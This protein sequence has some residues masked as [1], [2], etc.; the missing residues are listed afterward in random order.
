MLPRK[1]LRTR[2][3]RLV[4]LFTLVGS[5][6]TSLR[7]TVLTN[8]I[9][10]NSILGFT[11]LK[12]VTQP[13]EN[14]LFA[15]SITTN[16]PGQYTFSYAGV[17]ELYSVHAASF[18]LEFTP[19]FVRGSTPLLNNMDNPGSF[20]LSL[21][22]GQSVLL[23]Y[24]DDLYGPFPNPS[25]FGV[26]DD[27]DGYGWFKLTRTLRGLTVSDSATAIGG[28]IVVGTYTQIPE[29]ASLGLVLPALFGLTMR[30]GRLQF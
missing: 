7:A 10:F 9:G 26:P 21:G 6:F 23:A 29:P 22:V 13:G 20:Q 11:V 25:T 14:G 16:Q 18:G 2:V 28:G 12:Q 30:R 5:H 17:A 19:S 1:Y 4:I 3:F 24:W 15:L 27:Y 8:N